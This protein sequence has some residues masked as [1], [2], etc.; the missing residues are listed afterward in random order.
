[1]EFSGS[2]AEIIFES[3]RDHYKVLLV[4]G[5][6]EVLVVHGNL[7][8][9]GIGDHG[10]FRGRMENHPRFGDQLRVLSFDY[11]QPSDIHSIELFLSSG[12][13]RGLGPVLASR[14]VETFGARTLE[15]MSYEIEKLRRVP[16][17]GKK[18][19]ELIKRDYEALGAK[20]ESLIYIQSLGFSP[21]ISGRIISEFGP[22]A[23]QIIEDNPYCLMEVDGIGFESCE[24]LA[25]EQGFDPGDL[26]RLQA[27][28]KGL[29]QR[30]LNQ[31]H[32]YLPKWHI[33]EDMESL[34]YFDEENL[35]E[36][37]IQGS[38][39]EEKNRVY[40]PMAY[41]V[42]GKVAA[43]LTRLNKTE[44]SKLH[45]NLEALESSLSDE[46]LMAL[47]KSLNKSVSII[48]GGP[49]TGKTTLIKAMAE[50]FDEGLK[51]CA[52]T[53]R[54]AKRMEEATDHPAQTIHRLLEYKFDE[55]RAVLGFDRNEEN[56]LEA[57]VVVV[58]EVSMVDIFLM[59]NLLE[60]LEAGVR[61][62]LIGDEDQLPSVG[63]GRVL[64]DMIASGVIE[65]S[66]L[67]EIFRQDQHSLIPINAGKVLNGDRDL[68]RDSQGDF[69]ILS[70]QGPQGL[71]ELVRDRLSSYY[72]FDPLWEIQ[73]L[74]PM[75][76]GPLGTRS[77][78]Q[79]LQEALNPYGGGPRIQLGDSFFQIGD[80]IM[81]NRNNYQVEWRDLKSGEEGQ[82]IFN[83]DIG[84]IVDINKGEISIVFDR[85]RRAIYT[86]EQLF[87]I[88]HA[89]A[90]T[91][92]K[93]QGSEFA[94]V[95]LAAQG[96]PPMLA[97][98]NLL[99]TGIT[100]AKE[101]LVLYQGGGSLERMISQVD[102][103]ERY[104]SLEELLIDYNK[105]E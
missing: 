49:G 56:P 12:H 96:V 24:R 89:Y 88:D 94:C 98:R 42:E 46:Q 104:S 78:N 99:Y 79:Q 29:L 2:V 39:I 86:R 45:Y 32:I 5:K 103:Q 33:L 25:Q 75:K 80:K 19:L 48:T 44:P 52:P 38:F 51:L 87:D 84:E 70:S 16:G 50:L 9:L 10:T 76:N 97:N 54:A 15:V 100:R 1:M 13:I 72:N 101:L 61:L 93:S 85:T 63:P 59:K 55:E 27:F 69:F 67:R 22:A 64:G 30:A 83:G 66:R 105:E 95:V 53:G 68:L 17:I 14:I 71:V 37:F 18:T 102:S 36:L 60:A 90:M 20:K 11:D 74:S 35:R 43:Y 62:I 40:L 73:V 21:L 31:G 6:D 65:V 26:R 81:Q 23:R 8:G 34:G 82:G 41:E 58:D 91:I 28:I 4:E 77:L 92:H 57:D 3:T 7:P 47:E